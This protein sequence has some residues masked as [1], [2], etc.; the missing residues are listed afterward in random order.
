[1]VSEGRASRKSWLR[2]L[3]EEQKALTFSISLNSLRVCSDSADGGTY[4]SDGM[5]TICGVSGPFGI[6][7][8][9]A[10]MFVF[11]RCCLFVNPLSF[12]RTTMPRSVGK[13]V[14][15]LSNPSVTKAVL[16]M[17]TEFVRPP[18]R[19]TRGTT[20]PLAVL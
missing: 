4:V 11:F 1:M 16:S 13:V 19:T 20:L 9:W 7:I 6:C 15:V 2:L 18:I 8:L 3:N 14:L 5:I 12:I 17:E 10:K